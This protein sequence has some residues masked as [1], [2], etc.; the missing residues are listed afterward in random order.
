MRT[1][2]NFI[3]LF[4]TMALVFTSCDVS[5]DNDNDLTLL[6]PTAAEFNNLREEALAS[7]TQDFQIDAADG[8]VELF[9]ENGVRITLDGG[10][11]TNNGDPV[12]GMIDVEFVELFERGDMLATNK[13]TNGIMPGGDKAV[14]VSGGE[15]F[16]NATQNG[17]QLDNPCGIQLVVPANL[18]GGVDF[19]MTLWTG[20]ED[21]D[22]NND[23]RE[24]GADGQGGGELFAEGFNGEMAYY[25]FF[26][27]FG[28][29]NVDRF[30]N[31]PR[32]KTLIKVDV[33]EGY[34]NENSAVYLSYD[35]EGSA[36]ARLDVYNST[37]ELFSE[38]YG[39][40]PIGLECHVIFAT[41][42]NGNWRYAA[43]SVTIVANDVISIGLNETSVA[44][45]AQLT[46]IINGLP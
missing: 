33:P 36:L 2:I 24:A 39:Q 23:W 7:R 4:A 40:I 21:E 14:L 45:D 25:A 29:T 20:V 32:P 42:E 8:S 9:S 13:A 43:K 12:T 28:W 41:E 16:I 5:D 46:A 31:D 15:F 10:C 6:P 3:S 34:D 26:Q 37:E 38:H 11:M 19:D 44:S 1:L 17:E 30:Y 22:G 27:D 35:G 18:T